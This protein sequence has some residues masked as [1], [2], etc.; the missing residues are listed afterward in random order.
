[1][2]KNNKTICDY[3]LSVEKEKAIIKISEDAL[4]RV[5]KHFNNK[6]I[7]IYL[8]GIIS[9]RNTVHKAICNYD[10]QKRF[11]DNIRYYKR[12]FY[13]NRYGRGKSN[14]N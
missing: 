9:C 7:Y 5:I 13:Q 6:S 8:E 2:E 10:M 1:M 14:T 4:K 12:R 11:L 3:I